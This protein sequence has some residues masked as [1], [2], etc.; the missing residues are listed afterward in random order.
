[1]AEESKST[2]LSDFRKA[3]DSL[4][5]FRTRL[6]SRVGRG[7]VANLD[8]RDLAKVASAEKLSELDDP[9]LRELFNQSLHGRIREDSALKNIDLKGVGNTYLDFAFEQES[10]GGSAA[11]TTDA[12]GAPVAFTRFGFEQKEIT[13]TGKT[14]GQI[15]NDPNRKLNEQQAKLL[16]DFS[17]GLQASKE[18]LPDGSL[19][20]IRE[21]EESKG[22]LK[23]FQDLSQGL[24]AAEVQAERE[25]VNKG[26]NRATATADR[27]LRA[28]LAGRGVRGGIAGKQLADIQG[29]GIK[30]KAETERDLF[31]KQFSARKEGL[32][33]FANASFQS[34]TFDLQQAAKEKSIQLATATTFGQ[35]GASERGAKLQAEAISNQSTGG[36]SGGITVV[37]TELHRQG[38]I[39]TEIW[40]KNTDFGKELYRTNPYA[41][42]GYLSWGVSVSKLMRN[43]KLATTILAP[44]MKQWIYNIAGKETILN[45]IV[46]ETLFTF[47][48]LCGKV[49]Q[50]KDSITPVKTR[51]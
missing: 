39:P 49:L 31:L 13:D 25:M 14:A 50:Y 40:N 30:Q 47:S 37:C 10:K 22:I 7:R 19:G 16:G 12:S 34:Q 48:K 45:T 35:L 42:K 3:S 23:R 8:V 27:S 26:I 32:K 18:F 46:K 17:T 4:E 38:L 11:P 6:G 15:L 51:N 33:D 9:N 44:V 24:S 5:T 28:S 20:R 43:S 36:S 1:M 41:F 2:S 29:Q 21:S